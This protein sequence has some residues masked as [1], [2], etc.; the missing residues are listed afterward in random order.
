M[1]AEVD[2]ARDESW[3]GSF[4]KWLYLLAKPLHVGIHVDGLDNHLH[5]PMAHSYQKRGQG[6]LLGVILS[7]RCSWRW[8]LLGNMKPPSIDI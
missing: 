5:W 4:A 1:G 2:D 3:R 6:L 8:C 7:C